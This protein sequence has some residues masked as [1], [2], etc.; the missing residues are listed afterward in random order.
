M[1]TMLSI[2]YSK[3]YSLKNF[4]PGSFFIIGLLAIL[5]LLSFCKRPEKS[6]QK[7]NAT[8]GKKEISKLEKLGQDLYKK[9]ACHNC[10]GLYGKGDGPVGLTLKPAP[11]NY[12][13]MDSYKQG[14]E[15]KD[16]MN[17]LL[18]GVP[19]TLMAAYS[20]ISEEDRRAIASY[21]VYLQKKD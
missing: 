8:N 11:R 3:Y 19:G 17:T 10:H 12:K 2:S 21:V 14:S 13:D 16:I 5:L 20:H 15:L 18:T 4:P 6:E 1:T 9:N 7:A